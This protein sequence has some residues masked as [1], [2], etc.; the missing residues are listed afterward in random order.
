MKYRIKV[1]V[2]FEECG[3]ETE[4]GIKDIGQVVMS[5]DE[6]TSIDDVEDHLL[7]AG[8]DSMREAI[9]N[10]LENVSKKRSAAIHRK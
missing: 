2:E 3:D 5:E 9:V 10:H 7:T 6:S 4:C 8:Y 1:K